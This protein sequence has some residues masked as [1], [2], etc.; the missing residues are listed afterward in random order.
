MPI[1]N[2]ITDGAENAPENSLNVAEMR[3][4]RLTAQDVLLVAMYRNKFDPRLL[5]VVEHRKL[6]D[7]LVAFLI[8]VQKADRALR[9]KGCPQKRQPIVPANVAAILESKV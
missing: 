3:R 9:V 7:D 4:I 6:V 8:D 1:D 5:K 2:I